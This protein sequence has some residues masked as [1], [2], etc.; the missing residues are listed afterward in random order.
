L[1]ELPLKSYKGDKVNHEKQEAIDRLP[2]ILTKPVKIWPRK[3]WSP[4]DSNTRTGAN[5]FGHLLES[6]SD[7]EDSLIFPMP[8]DFQH[9]SRRH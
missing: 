5:A 3:L 4:R 7:F 6:F 2:R 9:A 8:Q 1:L